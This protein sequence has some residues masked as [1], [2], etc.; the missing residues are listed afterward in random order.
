MSHVVSREQ[1]IALPV[2]RISV[3]NMRCF[4]NG[5]IF[6]IRI[7]SISGRGVIDNQES[8]WLICHMVH[9][10]SSFNMQKVWFTI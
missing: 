7:P 10:K 5:N 4:H 8:F 2:N 6:I 3:I 1:E 9:D